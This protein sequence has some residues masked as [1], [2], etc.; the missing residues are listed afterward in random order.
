MHLTFLEFCKNVLGYFPFTFFCFS[1]SSGMGSSG[2]CAAA[3]PCA[4][5]TNI[6][7]YEITNVGR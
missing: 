5:L 4:Y 6:F 2:V 7:C 3:E 1:S